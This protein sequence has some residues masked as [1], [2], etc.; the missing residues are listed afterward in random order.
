MEQKRIDAC[1]HILMNK[2]YHSWDYDLDWGCIKADLSDGF[3]MKITDE[4]LDEVIE[5][6][7]IFEDE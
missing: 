5:R 7:A 4:D 3:N 1:A 6:M 2:G